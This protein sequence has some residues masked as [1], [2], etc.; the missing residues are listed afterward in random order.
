MSTYS[1]ADRDVPSTDW[2]WIFCAADN[3]ARTEVEQ[4]LVYRYA[5]G[6]GWSNDEVADMLEQVFGVD[7]V[8]DLDDTGYAEALVLIGR[9]D[10]VSRK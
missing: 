4:A 5:Y 1:N 9:Y 8:A 7:D 6:A 3:R 10:E 2:D